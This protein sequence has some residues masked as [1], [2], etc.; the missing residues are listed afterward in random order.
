MITAGSRNPETSGSGRDFREQQSDGRIRILF[1]SVKIVNN[2]RSKS[3]GQL[4][5]PIG[6]HF[7][8]G[9][10]DSSDENRVLQQRR[11]AIQSQTRVN[12]AKI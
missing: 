3:N 1:S 6:F 4:S 12:A 2:D 7:S 9:V 5:P 10:D 8:G 11:I